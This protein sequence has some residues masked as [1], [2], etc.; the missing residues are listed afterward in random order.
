MDLAATREPHPL[1]PRVMKSLA[2]GAHQ[3]K[4]VPCFMPYKGREN[5]HYVEDVG[6]HFAG[7]CMLPFEGCRALNIKGKTIEVTEFLDAISKVADEMGIAD[8]LETGIAPEATPNLFICDLDDSAVEEQFPGLPRTDI[9]EGIRKSLSI[10]PNN[11]VT[12]VEKYLSLL[13]QPRV[14]TQ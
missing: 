12:P 5:Y 4:T 2:L 13:R 14:L 3:G 1:R 8:F 10:F 7:V 9:A 11:M 6:A